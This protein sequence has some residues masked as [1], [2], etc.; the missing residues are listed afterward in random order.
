MVMKVKLLSVAGI[1]FLLFSSCSYEIDDVNP[2]E[3]SRITCVADNF[4][5]ENAVQ[6]RSAADVSNPE[7]I[8]F[9]WSA[10]DVVGIFPNQGT[11]IS[12]PMADGAG[13]ASA[14]FDG[15]G[16]AL[17]NGAAYYAYYPYNWEYC[18]SEDFKNKIPYTYVGQKAVFENQD[19]AVQLG[20][21]DYMYTSA[22]T[23]ASGS[24]NF[25][26]HH[27][28]ALARMEVTFPATAT[29]TKLVITASEAIFPVTGTFDLTAETFALKPSSLASSIEIDL[30]NLAGTKDG[31]ELVYF[32][33][34]PADCLGLES[35]A[36]ILIDS[37]NNKYMMGMNKKKIESGK[38]Y[39]WGVAIPELSKIDLSATATSNCYMVSFP[40]E[41]R[42]V[43]TKGNSSESVGEISNVEVLW[44]TLG[45]DVAPEA[46]DLIS[47]VSYQNGYITFNASA[48]KGNAL[49]AA[50]DDDGNILWSWHIWMTDPPKEQLYN[51]NAGTMMDRNLGATSASAGDVRAL[52]LLYQWG[53]K[54][55]FL[56]GES[57][58]GNIPAKSTLAT[59]PY[60]VSSNASNGT[61]AYATANPTTFIK[62]NTNN[63]DWYY[64]GK[65]ETDLTRWQPTK[66]IYDPC[67]VGY[68]VPGHDIAVV[69]VGSFWN[70]AFDSIGNFINIVFD[71]IN[72]G[73][74]FGGIEA[75]LNY[76]TTEE[77][78]Y[79]AAGNIECSDAYGSLL[80]V[81]TAGRYWTCTRVPHVGV[82][83]VADLVFFNNGEVSPGSCMSSRA[84]GQSVRCLKEE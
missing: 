61:I 57:I 18:E 26:F 29:Y 7:S 77:C 75:A 71:D 42:F 23:P 67:P 2:D 69:G 32:M 22:S 84:I 58:S 14:T 38:A 17:R 76:I 43:P 37:D 44:E 41:Y 12:F 83:N 63:Y 50:K 5:C 82:T 19:G 39:S 16:W 53:R 66:T 31:K 36:A 70:I 54:D 48:R 13:A 72:C 3:L 81:G 6:T 51:N 60:P 59:W 4:I 24:V 80:N 25:A 35:F 9:Q 27:V 46:G 28:G 8:A 45:T 1:I 49:I 34:P 73:Y 64:S 21:Y 10:D 33:L 20:A 65:H 74:Y 79:P 62:Y 11:Q 40:G 47:S 55:P 56:S 15:G 30:E 78:W 68:R 52:G